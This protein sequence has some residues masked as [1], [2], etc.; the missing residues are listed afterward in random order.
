MSL[1]AEAEAGSFITVDWTGPQ[2]RGDFID[3]VTPDH[4]KLM[5]SPVGY[6]WANRGSPVELR[7]PTAVGDYIVRYIANTVA[8]R[9]LQVSKP[10]TI[11]A[12]SATFQAPESVVAGQEFELAW[13][14]P[15]RGGDLVSIVDLG[16]TNPKKHHS[17]KWARKGEAKMKAPEK[18]GSYELLYVLHGSGPRLILTRKKL[19]V[20]A[21]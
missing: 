5:H 3:I 13:E 9:E 10:I 16:E 11:T 4:S 18:P 20:T 7:A 2:G 12:A 21:P 15:N 8:G 1:P 17:Y 6:K 14:G 19:Q